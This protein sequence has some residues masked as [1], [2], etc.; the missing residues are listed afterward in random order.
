MK[1][2]W[3]LGGRKQQQRQQREEEEAVGEKGAEDAAAVEAMRLEKLAEWR[4]MMQ[5]GE[6]GVWFLFLSFSLFGSIDDDV[7]PVRYI[8]DQLEVD[9]HTCHKHLFLSCVAGVAPSHHVPHP[10]P[11]VLLYS[12]LCHD[13]C[14]VENWCFVGT[15]GGATV[16]LYFPEFL[17]VVLLGAS[18]STC[19]QT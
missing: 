10:T 4:A 3:N 9:V 6:V 18:G 19:S 15:Q 17:H 5:S 7:V 1:K 11:A 12:S 13:A 16:Q 14:A 2:G 8:L